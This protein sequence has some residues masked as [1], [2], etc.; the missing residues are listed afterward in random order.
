MAAEHHHILAYGNRCY[1]KQCECCHKI[2]L[3]YDNI[4]I[5]LTQPALIS[6]SLTIDEWI[7]NPR[8]PLFRIR[9]ANILVTIKPEDFQDFS[10]TIQIAIH[11]L[12]DITEFSH[13]TRDM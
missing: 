11:N 10:Q 7:Q 6:L 1:L 5:H 9:I 2:D 8:N 3:Y 4:I 13:S 12:L